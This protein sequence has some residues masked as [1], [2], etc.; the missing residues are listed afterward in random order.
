MENGETLKAMTHEP[1]NTIWGTLGNPV[2]LIAVSILISVNVLIGMAIFGSDHGVL[3]SMSRIDYA[4]GLITYLFA[5]VTIGTAVLLIVS[6]LTGTDDLAHQ[7]RFQRGKEILSLLLGLFGTIVGFYFG[8]EIS[9]GNVAVLQTAPL[10]VGR[11]GTPPNSKITVT[12]Y[13]SGG[14]APY[15]YAI[16]IGDAA[17]GAFEPV[18]GNGWIMKELDGAQSAGAGSSQISIDVRDADGHSSHQSA[19]LLNQP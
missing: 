4:R 19:V 15:E 17:R 1:R 5:I 10:R 18:P 8:S 3:A 6:A 7:R 13:V 12:T 11:S 14:K 2:V 9:Q 16:T